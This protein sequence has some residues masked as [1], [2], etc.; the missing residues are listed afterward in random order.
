MGVGTCFIATVL[1][2]PPILRIFAKASRPGRRHAAVISLLI[3]TA[4]LTLLSPVRLSAQGVSITGYYE[5]TL[6]VD[7]TRDT[8]EQLLD[9]S[10][11]RLDLTS[12]AG[13]GLTFT[14]NVNWI[15]YH[16]EIVRD[17]AP[18]LPE[19]VGSVLSAAG[20]PAV[21]ALDRERIFLDNAF[22]SWDRGA[23]RFRAGKQQLSWGPAYSFNPTD[24]FHRK[25]LLDPT[26]EKEG[27]T[28]LRFDVRW[29]FGSQVSLIAAP[30]DDLSES[31]YALRF[32]THIDAIGYD[33][34]V[35]LHAV[36][37][38]TSLDPTTF[39]TRAQRREAI[40]LE[41]TGSML[42]LGVWVEGNYN[43]METEENFLRAVGGLDYT[44]P[45]GLYLLYERLYN[46]R[47]A[48]DTPYPVGDWLANLSYGEPVGQGWHLLGL[49]KDLTDLSAGSLY[50][51]VANDGSFVLNPRLDLSVAQDADL[52]VFG[53]F[54]FGEEEG[55]FPPGL[56]TMVARLTIYF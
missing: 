16:G 40:G 14:G 55:A 4:C 7:Y 54:T 19:R 44:L 12:N 20:V 34:A 3:L 24:L 8:K 10:K 38:S 9:A 25:T 5:N 13:N 53:G 29:G 49:R 31:G 22:L 41:L 23:V 21:Y 36:T 1:V 47:A 33:A 42:G 35:T 37:D 11:L 46:E 51:F 6:Q 2:L 43:Q 30:G 28:A 52:I 15:V 56:S 48:A 45:G 32:S 18:Y 26:Y 39:L 17:L 50:V 27:V